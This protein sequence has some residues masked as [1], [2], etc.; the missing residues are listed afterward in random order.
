LSSEASV[1][2]VEKAVISKRGQPF[3]RVVVQNKRREPS[4]HELFDE[5]NEESKTDGWNAA[6]ITIIISNI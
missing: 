2:I 1:R 5:R 4:L 3:E 6:I